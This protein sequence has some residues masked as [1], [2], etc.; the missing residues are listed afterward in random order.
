MGGA[1]LRWW[2]DQIPCVDDDAEG[3]KDGD[4]ETPPEFHGRIR[5][6]V[7]SLR[8]KPAISFAGGASVENVAWGLCS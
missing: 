3:A 4:E 8:A 2:Q 7:T 6:G 1:P 5:A